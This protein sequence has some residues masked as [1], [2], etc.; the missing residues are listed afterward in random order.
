MYFMMSPD[1]A[2]YFKPNEQPERN[3]TANQKDGQQLQPDQF[4]IHLFF[5]L[6]EDDRLVRTI[7]RGG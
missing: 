2:V 6:G 3:E 1:D 5:G 7:G 4:P